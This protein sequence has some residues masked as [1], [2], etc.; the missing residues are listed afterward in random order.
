MKK[1]PFDYSLIE[2]GYKVITRDGITIKE[3]FFFKTVS[4]DSPI[5]GVVAGELRSWDING[6]H[7]Y[8]RET[9]YDLFLIPP[10]VEKYH[11][12]CLS[13][14][15]GFA[16]LKEAVEVKLTGEVTGKVTY[17][18]INAISIELITP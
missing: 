6:R 1:L 15:S 17:S 10:T 18:G 5:L 13:S 14:F 12:F 9:G 11:N 4:M 16:T 8:V 2:K 7:S 3:I